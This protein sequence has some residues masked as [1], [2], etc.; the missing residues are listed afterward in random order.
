MSRYNNYDEQK[1]AAFVMDES[2]ISSDDREI[3][4]FS[5]ENLDLEMT[6]FNT[7]EI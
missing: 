5:Y 2:R 7:N 6:I 3:D 4:E 1:Y